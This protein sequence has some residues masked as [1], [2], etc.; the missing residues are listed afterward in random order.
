MTR[1][2]NGTLTRQQTTRQSSAWPRPGVLVVGREPQLLDLL[3]LGFSYEGFDV[4]IATTDA[5]AQRAATTRHPDLILLHA[6]ELAGDDAPEHLNDLLRTLRTQTD[7]CV[8]LVLGTA[9]QTDDAAASFERLHREADGYVSQPFVFAELMACVR[10]LLARRG[11]DVAGIL[12][13]EDVTLDRTG[14]LVT[15]GERPIE[16]T[17]REFELL[18]LFLRRPGEVLSRGTILERIWGASYTGSDNI[19]DVYIHL[20]R[21]KLGDK[22]PRL[23]RTVRGAGYVLRG[24]GS[25]V[26]GQKRRVG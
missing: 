26:D 1:R 21:A 12:S 7:D 18:E 25:G 13:F 14:H 8:M 23:I 2:T 5:A 24:L 15:R 22:P 10:A 4:S 11:K 17:L 3:Q 16:L 19:L 6:A 9:K 20:L